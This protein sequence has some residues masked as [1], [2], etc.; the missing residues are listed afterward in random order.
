LSALL[1]KIT[2]HPNADDFNRHFDPRAYLVEMFSEPDDEDHFSISFITR[3]LRTL[4][5]ELLVHEFGGGPTLYSVAA[6]AARAR[7]IHFSDV[8]EASLREVG[9][10]LQDDPNAHDWNAYIALALEAEGLPATPGAIEARAAR[11]RQVVSELMRCDGQAASPIALKNIQ[12]DLVSAHHCTDVAA[13]TVAEWGQVIRNLTGLIRP[14]G[15]LMLSITT[16]ANTYQVGEVTFE[17][18][19]LSQQDIHDV[20]SAN[21]YRTES[22]ILET[23]HVKVPREYSGI[24]CVLA[25]QKD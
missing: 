3:A 8:V 20:L 9:L 17:C 10:W 14:G 25:Q 19:N 11:M 23:Y 15:W 18:V 13:S 24:V 1:T 12:Y 7:E 2:T 6:L 16:G 21:G 4:P 22:T 5:D